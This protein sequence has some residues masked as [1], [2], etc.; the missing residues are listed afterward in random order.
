MGGGGEQDSGP[1]ERY[2]V[3]PWYRCLAHTVEILDIAFLK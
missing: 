1:W 2:S 3:V